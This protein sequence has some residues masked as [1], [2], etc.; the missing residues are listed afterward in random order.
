MIGREA[1]AAGLRLIGESWAEQWVS[2][3]PADVAGQVE[4]REFAP[5]WH[6]DKEGWAKVAEP[7]IVQL[8]SLPKPR[9]PRQR[10]HRHRVM[11]F[12]VP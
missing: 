10:L 3:S 9:Q 12:S 6:L 8:M 11:V 4:R 5:L 7:V 2:Q 1:A